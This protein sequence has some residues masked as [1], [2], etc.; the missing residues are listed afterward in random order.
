MTSHRSGNS[1]II[2]VLSLM[3]LAGGVAPAR[4]QSTPRALV[5]PPAAQRDTGGAK[6]APPPATPLPSSL[7]PQAAN[8]ARLAPSAPV[9]LPVSPGGD[10]IPS[11]APAEHI[12]APVPQP[13]TRPVPPAP[14]S[15][16]QAALQAVIPDLPPPVGV[17]ARCKDGTYLTSAPSPGE[18][19]SNG[20][21]AV[22]FPQRAPGVAAP[23]VRRQ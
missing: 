11:S 8:I 21:L 19:V 20:G 16:Q 23:P 2:V 7:R 9:V 4:A 14:T 5:Q 6:L 22:R 3:A 12:A 17:T 15:L 1:R 10:P 18:C 13:L